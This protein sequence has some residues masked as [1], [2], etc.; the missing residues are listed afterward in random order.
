MTRAPLAMAKRIP[1]ARSFLGVILMR[2]SWSISTGKM[3][4]PLFP[5]NCVISNATFVP[6]PFNRKHRRCHRRNYS[7]VS[8]PD[9]CWVEIAGIGIDAGIEHRD[10]HW[11]QT[12]PYDSDYQK[13]VNAISRS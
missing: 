4:Q 10:D 12:P 1:A 9:K 5:Q 11:I 13:V 7:R 8:R 6:W 2:F 3:R